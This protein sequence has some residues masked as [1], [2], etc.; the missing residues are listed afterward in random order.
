MRMLN[1]VENLN[2]EKI[3]G[4]LIISHGFLDFFKFKNYHQFEMYLII[5]LLNFFVYFM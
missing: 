2:L 4:P 1:L 3:L 5:S